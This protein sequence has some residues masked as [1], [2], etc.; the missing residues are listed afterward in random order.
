M[1]V[2]TQV[3]N[4]W[5][6]VLPFNDMSVYN[7]TAVRMHILNDAGGSALTGV[8]FDVARDITTIGYTSV[9]YHNRGVES[10]VTLPTL[11]A[12]ASCLFEV[13]IEEALFFRF[14]ANSGAPT[15]LTIQYD[16]ISEQMDHTL[17]PKRAV[18]GSQVVSISGSASTALPVYLTSELEIG[19]YSTAAGDFTATVTNGTYNIV[20]ST[21]TLGGQTLTEDH[22][23][24]AE[25]GV[26]Q[27]ATE[28]SIVII[29][30]DFTWTPG[31]LTLD[32]TNCTNAFQ[33]A[34]G[35]VV[36]MAI[37]SREKAYDPT[38]DATKIVG[39]QV[40]DAAYVDKSVGVGGKYEAT[41]AAVGD[42]D[43]KPVSIDAKGNQKVVGDIAHDDIDEGNPVKIGGKAQSTPPADV[44]SGDRVDAYFDLKGRA[45]NPAYDFITGADKNS[46]INEPPP[47]SSALVTFQN[48]ATAAANGT[49]YTNG[50]NYNMYNI[51][52]ELIHGT[53]TSY[54]AVYL[55]CSSD[56]STWHQVDSRVTTAGSA[57]TY[58][59]APFTGNR[60]AKYWRVRFAIGASTVTCTVKG[61]FWRF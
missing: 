6:T 58:D 19:K 7:N 52:P 11:A 46:P 12:G 18:D 44:A 30:D 29:L 13:N 38:A 53:V 22:M 23:Q 39:T 34:T 33:F 14:R 16:L 47:Y 55:E 21:G 49:V 43:F 24:T 3:V 40:D 51:T 37:Y 35:D 10:L 31:T 50:D 42:G 45:V 48:A 56:N 57:T 25:L 15:T 17:E 32:T 9:P 26:Y 5:T 36:S 27:A 59:L 28:E 1:P 2:V 41:P 54:G 8:A 61:Y 20:L 4:G 60:V